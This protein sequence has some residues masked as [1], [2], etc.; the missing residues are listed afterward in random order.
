MRPEFLVGDTAIEV[1]SSD[2]WDRTF[3]ANINGQ[4][5]AVDGGIN[6]HFAH[7]ADVADSFW[8]HVDRQRTS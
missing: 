7:V 5:I 3:R 1:M 4:V 8:E 6:A 2:S